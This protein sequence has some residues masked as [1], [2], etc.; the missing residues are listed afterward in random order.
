MIVRMY[1]E[2]KKCNKAQLFHLLCYELI[3]D[4]LAIYALCETCIDISFS[5]IMKSRLLFNMHW[6]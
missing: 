6:L 4:G 3:N 1:W 2:K 5:L